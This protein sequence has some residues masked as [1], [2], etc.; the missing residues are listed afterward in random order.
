MTLRQWAGG[1]MPEL[2]K[3]PPP[4]PPRRTTWL[5]RRRDTDFVTSVMAA[6]RG[7]FAKY[8][9]D[10]APRQLVGLR[11]IVVAMQRMADAGLYDLS[12]FFYLSSLPP[13]IGKTVTMT[14]TIWELLRRPQYQHVGAIVFLF[15]LEEIANLIGAMGLEPDDYSI[16]VS[17]ESGK[18]F[19]TLGNPHPD[20]ARVIFTTQAQLQNRSVNYYVQFNKLSDFYYRGMARQVRLWDESIVPSAVFT[21]EEDQIIG[22]LPTVRAHNSALYETLDTFRDE[23]K[24]KQSGDTIRVPLIQG[25]YGVGEV[26]MTSWFPDKQAVAVRALWS[27]Q[28]RLC[29]VRR[30]KSM[31][32]LDYED[33][34][35]A[36]LAPMLILDASGEHR[37]TYPHWRRYSGRVRHLSSPQKNYEGATWHHWDH[38]AGHGQWHPKSTAWQPII[39]AVAAEIA[40]IPEGESV[41]LF[42]YLPD[43]HTVDV[44]ALIRKKLPGREVHF[45]NWGRH[46]ATNSFRDDRYVFLLGVMQ[47][48]PSVIEAI[49]RSVQ[50]K[51]AEDRFTQADHDDI[52]VGEAA[53]AIYQAANRGM[54]RKSRGAGV[55][56]GLHLYTVFSSRGSMPIPADLVPRIFPGI[57]V[58]PWRPMGVAL[59]GK[60]KAMADYIVQR[61]DGQERVS[62]AKADLKAAAGIKGDNLGRTLRHP[63]LAEWLDHNELGLQPDEKSITVHLKH[64]I[65]T[66]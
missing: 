25:R 7:R 17:P 51:W 53:H 5:P 30:N 13:G 6:V 64:S 52:R 66:Y 37:R 4:R 60:V 19:D 15:Q 10:P 24:R 57:A 9:H 59:S 16:V 42:H 23:L 31:A 32:V 21:L 40:Q 47:P 34:I 54:L 33:H 12:R 58:K 1:L 3:P 27:L 36:D 2:L 62:I 8:G 63:A 29:P 61:L 45:R 14:E 38:P 22:M 50:G 49:G 28:D 48:P 39:E 35:A 26:K 65:R 43:A 55:P 41:L 44:P 56:E 18:Q 11:Q 46:A 20:A